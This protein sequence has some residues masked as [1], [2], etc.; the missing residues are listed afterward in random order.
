MQLLASTSAKEMQPMQVPIIRMDFLNLVP[1]LPDTKGRILR[2]KGAFIL[3]RLPPLFWLDFEIVNLLHL[4]E[5]GLLNYSLQ[6]SQ[7][8]S[9]TEP[10]L[11]S[12]RNAE[13][14][15][16]SN[17]AGISRVPETLKF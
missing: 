2:R 3:L 17:S 6:A 9:S 15:G 1:N 4:V 12:P 16:K 5:S 7:L 14:S 11:T 8:F 10:L 13:G